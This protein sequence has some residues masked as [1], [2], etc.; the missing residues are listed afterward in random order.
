LFTATAVSE[1]TK[2]K[3]LNHYIF[4]FTVVTIFYLPL[5]FVTALYALD[6]F[7][8]DSPNQ[9]TSFVVTLLLVAGTTYGF[10]GFL[11]WSVRE[12]KRRKLLKKAKRVKAFGS[13]F[14]KKLRKK[15]VEEEGDESESS[16]S[17][18]E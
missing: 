4:V 5:T 7:S 1:A 16:E 10:A 8:W 2:A 15:Q 11:I 12:P 13:L 3:Q 6:L 9:K 17:D 14:K 18:T